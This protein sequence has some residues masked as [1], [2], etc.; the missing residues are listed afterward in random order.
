MCPKSHYPDQAMT[1]YNQFQ[2]CHVHTFVAIIL[3]EGSTFQ[4]LL[5]EQLLHLNDQTKCSLSLVCNFNN[6]SWNN[7]EEDL[8]NNGNKC[9]PLQFMD[10]SLALAM[11]LWF[12]QLCNAHYALMSATPSMTNFST[13][14]LCRA[15]I[16]FT[17]LIGT[18]TTTSLRQCEHTS[19]R[20]HCIILFSIIP[21]SNP[22]AY[23]TP[24]EHLTTCD[25]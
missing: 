19:S 2:T 23:S 13:S 11:V 7:Y 15:T 12:W 4:R 14:C 18:N 22:P 10:K 3:K 17:S 20:A 24:N 16:K 1:C 9:L 21:Y 25:R 5:L 8:Q 6:F